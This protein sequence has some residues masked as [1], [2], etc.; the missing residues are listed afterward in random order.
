MKKINNIKY[1][2][3][4][5]IVFGSF[6]NFAHNEYGLTISKYCLA[7]LFLVF[8][9]ESIF[10][11]IKLKSTYVFI[12]AL[13]IALFC[14]G[15]F[16]KMQH[17]AGASI[18]L[19]I[20][21]LTLTVFYIIRGIRMVIKERKNSLVIALLTFGVYLWV[22]LVFAGWLFK[23]LHYPGASMFLYVNIVLFSLLI[24]PVLLRYNYAGEK[25]WFFTYLKTL[26]GNIRL[27][28]IVFSVISLHLTLSLADIVPKFYSLAEPPALEKLRIQALKGGVKEEEPYWY[29]LFNYRNFL[30]NRKQAEK[31]EQ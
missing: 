24:I 22:G 3:F 18:I 2:L 31:K 15:Y 14:L 6:A 10:A 20:S 5:L 9:T 13:F 11:K 27:L 26:K 16:F 1:I 21:A 7:G 23:L 30:D 19:I 29:Y 12:E 8:L 17:W 28:L 4:S 25:I